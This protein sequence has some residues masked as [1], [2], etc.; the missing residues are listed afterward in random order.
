MAKIEQKRPVVEEIAALVNGAA[1]VV[2]T[3]ARGL[4]VEQDTK[5][6]KA[7]RENGVTYK[8]YKNTML[9]LAFTGTEFESLKADLKG[10]TAIAVSKE[11]GTAPARIL[12]QHAKEFKLLELKSAVVDGTYYDTKGVEV[13]STIPSRNELLS[14]FLGSIQSPLANFARVVNQI[15]EKAEA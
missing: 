14:K 2:L 13:L 8:V 9:N 15:A 12:A 3:D 7:L 1:G 4:T 5:L 6:R 11:D 10:P